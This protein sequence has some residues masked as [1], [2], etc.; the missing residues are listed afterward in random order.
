MY[1]CHLT[2]MTRTKR[3]GI[4]KGSQLP[5][6]ERERDDAKY[7]P[8]D[9]QQTLANARNAMIRPTSGKATNTAINMWSS[10]SMS[11]LPAIRKVIFHASRRVG[12]GMFGGRS[13]RT[14]KSRCA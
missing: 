11:L 7:L 10:A 12:E 3:H 13:Q 9:A 6:R 5:T 14:E 4:E 2:P 8:A 1:D